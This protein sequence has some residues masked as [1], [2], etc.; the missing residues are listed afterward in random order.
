MNKS[1]NLPYLATAAV[2]GLIFGIGLYISGMVNPLKVLR[3]LDF[4]AIPTGGWDPSLAFVMGSALVVMF[5]AVQL[6]KRREKPVFDASLMSIL[7]TSTTGS[8]PAS[9][10]G[11]VP[12]VSSSRGL[13]QRASLS[14]SATNSLCNNGSPPVTAT[15]SSPPAAS[16][17]AACASTSAELSGL[18]ATRT[19]P[20]GPC[21]CTD[22]DLSKLAGVSQ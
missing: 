13:G 4:T 14:T 8:T 12:L 1:L 18:A 6:G 16:S 10:S 21:T 11:S 22:A 19:R 15:P 7:T 9:L 3:F 20:S 5:I 2:A 17:G